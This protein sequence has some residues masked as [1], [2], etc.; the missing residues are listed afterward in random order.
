[1]LVD[2]ERPARENHTN[3]KIISHNAG[4]AYAHMLLA[5]YSTE[6]K[7]PQSQKPA[8][9]TASAATSPAV[10]SPTILIFSKRTRKELLYKIRFI[11]LIRARLNE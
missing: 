9:T 3:I 8:P 6:C 7:V 2:R 11:V 1:M 4:W 5:P 10:T